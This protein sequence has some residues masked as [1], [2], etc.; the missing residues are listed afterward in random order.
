M[1]FFKHLH[2]VCKHRRLVRKLCFTVGL[3]WQGLSRDLSK[4]SPKEFNPGVKYYQGNRSPQSRERELFGYSAAWLH[5]KG[6][7]KHHFEYWSE[8]KADGEVKFFEMPPKYF[9]EMVC[10]RI[11]ACK[12]YRGKEY[13]ER[14]ALDYFLS[15]KD[16]FVMNPKTAERLEYFL[17]L[18]AEQGEKAMFKEL[19]KFVKESKKKSK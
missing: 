14:S 16:K 18:L 4:F 7:N 19:K 6:R 1:K 3:V 10:D 9:A 15:R 8:V 13:T 17:T 2:T 5:H 11:A 12:V